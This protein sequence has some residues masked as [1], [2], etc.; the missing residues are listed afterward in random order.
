MIS[1]TEIGQRIKKA[2]LSRG[3]P[4]SSL[5]V[6][7]GVT[8]EAI[9]L[10]ESGKR[11][12][13]LEDLSRLAS[14]L[15]VDFGFLVGFS[16]SLRL[17]DEIDTS[18]QIPAGVMNAWRGES[19]IIFVMDR[20]ELEKY[21]FVRCTAKYTPTRTKPIRRHQQGDKIVAYAE[22]APGA[23]RSIEGFLRRVF[24]VRAGDEDIPNPWPHEHAPRVEAVSWWTI[25]AG[26]PAIWESARGIGAD[27]A[28]APGSAASDPPNVDAHPSSTDSEITDIVIRIKDL[29]K[30]LQGIA[31]R[32]IDGV[33]SA[34]GPVVPK[35]GS[36]ITPDDK[37]DHH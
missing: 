28:R 1:Q 7:F 12:L 22:L 18:G 20:E 8:G 3:W 33:I 13:S 32:Q 21:A 9:S 30:E 36:D 2:R 16:E 6:R 25:A 15:G 29:P 17:H 5:G 11:A 35:R 27:R 26:K 19:T 34:F 14:T 10:Y 24:Y 37:G 31:L 23:E 4:Q